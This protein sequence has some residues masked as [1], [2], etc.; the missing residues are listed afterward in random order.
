MINQGEEKEND[1]GCDWQ[2]LG[3]SIESTQNTLAKLLYIRTGFLFVE[4]EDAHR[5]T[6]TLVL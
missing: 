5:A 1:H 4:V 6:F 3:I 2:Q